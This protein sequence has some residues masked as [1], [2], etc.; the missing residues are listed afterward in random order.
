MIILHEYFQEAYHGFSEAPA[1]A[2]KAA[3]PV[4]LHKSVW[5]L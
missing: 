2:E 4:N 1:I 3:N 5:I